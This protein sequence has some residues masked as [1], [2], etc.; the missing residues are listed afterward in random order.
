MTTLKGIE[1][2][3]KLTQ[4]LLDLKGKILPEYFAEPTIQ[5]MFN[6]EI[7]YDF[8]LYD[9]L[10]G[11][12]G[13]QRRGAIYLGGHKGEMLLALVLL[14]FK[15]I[16]VVEPQPELFQK[17]QER[18]ALINQF[19]NSYERLIGGLEFTSIEIFQAA[20]GAIDGEA[21]LYVTSESK[22]SSLFKPKEKVINEDTSY[23]E[24]TV[25]NKIIVPLKTIDSLI[26][27]SSGELSDFDFLYM[28]IQGS[29]LN[30]LEGA[31][32][33]LSQLDAIYLE[34]NMI[35]RYEA[36]PDSEEI[37]PYLID[38]NFANVWGYLVEK[39]GVRFDLYINQN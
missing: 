25:S 21:E 12:Y 22:L 16:I 13:C 9:R 15:K 6:Q 32:E 27:E 26:E 39:Y 24:V 20:V 33:T 2:Q 18:I 36:C 34:K 8:L 38:R 30:A 28:N 4:E 1:S 31:K 7:V 19:L 29:E 37:D 23:S 17:L 5:T 11:K 14:G 10:L 3:A 35:P